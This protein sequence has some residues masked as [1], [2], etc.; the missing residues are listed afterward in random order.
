MSASK[1]INDYLIKRKPLVF[2]PLCLGVSDKLLTLLKHR[3]TEIK[4]ANVSLYD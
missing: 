1:F 2:V 3:G 4:N